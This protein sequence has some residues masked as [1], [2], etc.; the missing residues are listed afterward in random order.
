MTPDAALTYIRGQLAEAGLDVSTLTDRE[1]RDGLARLVD[2]FTAPHP[3][4]EFARAY[5]DGDALALLCADM[6]TNGASLDFGRLM[7]TTTVH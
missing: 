5:A 7:A 1:L 3:D 6:A 4:R 2:I